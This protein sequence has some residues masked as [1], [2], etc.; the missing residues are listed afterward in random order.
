MF[1]GGNLMSFADVLKSLFE[2]GL[3]SFTI[4]SLF[5]EDKYIA[6]EEKILCKIKRNKLKT[7]PDKENK[8]DTVI[9]YV[10]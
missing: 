4:W 10:R 3:V 7:V 2:V 8:F 1:G 6:F 9:R 5:H